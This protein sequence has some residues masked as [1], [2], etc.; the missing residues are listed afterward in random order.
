MW[1]YAIIGFLIGVIE[2]E[3]LYHLQIKGIKRILIM[4]LNTVILIIASYFV[5]SYFNL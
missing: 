3:I 4:I 1:I 2:I 5:L